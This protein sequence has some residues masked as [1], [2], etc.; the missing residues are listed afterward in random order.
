MFFKQGKDEIPNCKPNLVEIFSRRK[1][2]SVKTQGKMKMT[3]MKSCIFS[4]IW[5]EISL[6]NISPRNFFFFSWR[7]VFESCL[8]ILENPKNFMISFFH[9]LNLSGVVLGENLSSLLSKGLSG[10]SVLITF[11]SSGLRRKFFL[12]FILKLLQIQSQ[13][14]HNPINRF[15]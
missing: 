11:I 15:H 4:K 14:N 13:I 3:K 6:K 10:K 5:K 2:I 7:N 9:S 12:P 1:K 8:Q